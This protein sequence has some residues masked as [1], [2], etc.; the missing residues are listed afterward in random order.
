VN[1]DGS[2]TNTTIENINEL[3][4]INGLFFANVWYEDRI[5]IINPVTGIVEYDVDFSTLWPQSARSKV[6]ADVLNGISLFD[7]DEILVTGKLWPQLY[8]VKLNDI[9]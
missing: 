6:G 7:N 1:N 5:L 8:R 2:T 4:Y 3:E 9:F